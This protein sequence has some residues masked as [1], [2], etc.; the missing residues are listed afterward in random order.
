MKQTL[1]ALLLGWLTLVPTKIHA[2]ELIMLEQAGCEWCLEWDKNIGVI[3]DKTE[4]G[5]K[6]H[7]RRIQIYAPLPNDLKFLTGLVFT[8]TFILVDNGVEIGRIIGYPGEHFF[9]G[10]LQDLVDKLPE[11]QNK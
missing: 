1:F 5:K 4:V 7:L 8:P 2:A 11:E 9:W 10:M 6:S 3:Y